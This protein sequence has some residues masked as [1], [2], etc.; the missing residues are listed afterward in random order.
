MNLF[1]LVKYGLLV[2]HVMRLQHNESVDG[3]VA[4]RRIPGIR[5]TDCE[6]VGTELKLYKY[7]ES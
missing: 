1:Q 2:S 7:G 3:Q 4:G 5:K 6:S